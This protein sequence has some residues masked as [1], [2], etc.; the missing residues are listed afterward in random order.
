M[1]NDSLPPTT[2]PNEPTGADALAA[3]ARTEQRMVRLTFWQTLLSVAGA[4]IAILALFATLRESNEVRRQTAAAVWPYVQVQISDF[5]AGEKAAFSLS[6]TNTGV[7]PAKVR[8]LRMEI[9]GEPVPDWEDLLARLGQSPDSPYG[10]D[11]ISHRVLAPGESVTIFQTDHPPL[12][13]ALQ[14]AIRRPD[15]VL[16][17]CYCSIFDECWESRSDAQHSDPAPVAACPAA[18]A[19]QFEG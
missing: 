18:G 2:P 16:S 9:A 14:A 3:L 10:R 15:S 11:F 1:T 8:S 17:M 6:F 12:V 7:G 4:L 19:G 13:R 5:D